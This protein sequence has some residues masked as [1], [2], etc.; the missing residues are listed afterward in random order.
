MEHE[1]LHHQYKIVRSLTNESHV[2]QFGNKVSDNLLSNTL[3]I[4]V[5]F[6]FIGL[7]QRKEERK[8]IRK[9]NNKT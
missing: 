2:Q 3:N 4:V 5:V 1:S 6:T 7:E 9:E 8:I